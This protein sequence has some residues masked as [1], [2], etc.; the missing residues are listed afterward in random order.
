MSEGR[1]PRAGQGAWM[2]RLVA[3]PILALVLG[4]VDTLLVRSDFDHRP[5]EASLFVQASLLWLVF[6]IL[7]LVPAAL[8]SLLWRS[9]RR[10]R[11]PGSRVAPA[12]TLA[13]WM[14]A[15]VL[16][17]SV[18]DPY[19]A[20]G[21]D[22]SGL[23]SLEPW[24]KVAGAL[25]VLVL[26]L[27]GLRRALERLPAMRVGTGLALLALVAGLAVSFHSAPASP[28]PAGSAREGLPNL[29]LVVWDTARSRSLSNYGYERE[30]TPHLARLTDES[31][32]FEDAR[33]V[34]C[35]TLTSH[36]VPAS[37]KPASPESSR[38]AQSS[39]RSG[40]A[41][42]KRNSS[43]PTST[44]RRLTATRLMGLAC[45]KP[46][47]PGRRIQNHLLRPAA[48]SRGRGCR[49]RRLLESRRRTARTGRVKLYTLTQ[50]TVHPR[51]H[52][53]RRRRARSPPRKV[54]LGRCQRHAALPRDRASDDGGGLL[55][56]VFQ[57]KGARSQRIAK[58]K[59]RRVEGFSRVLL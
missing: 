16:V 42:V 14:V 29:L 55:I 27:W 10:R 52:G 7:A 44:L 59:K 23:R 33:S 56:R 32:L 48:A 28:L 58:R 47:D 34:S 3:L 46:F 36:R 2:A 41:S 54:P 30:T 39:R 43:A 9:L 31:I 12:V 21:G 24:L 50:R 18:L 37:K 6:G 4:A 1:S 13:G 17:H 53:T 5:L 49:I 19:T 35:Y 45:G 22:L 26:V 8:G 25:L 51:L 40:T 38:A 11:E 20:L 57:R 15:P